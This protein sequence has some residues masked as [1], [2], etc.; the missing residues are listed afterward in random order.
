MVVQGLHES[1]TRVTFF[2]PATG[3]AEQ[4]AILA[5]IRYLEEQRKK[6]VSVTGFTRSQ[7]HEPIYF[8]EWWDDLIMNWVRERVVLFII[9]YE[10]YHED[11]Q[12]TS[13]LRR[14]KRAIEKRFATYGKEQKVIWILAQAALRFV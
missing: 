11:P 13:A 5:V 3:A 6:Q 7:L 4:K 9:D 10:L 12:L 2:L 1:R 8:G 14:L